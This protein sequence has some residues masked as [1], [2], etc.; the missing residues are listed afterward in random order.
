[1]KC[2][3]HFDDFDQFKQAYENVAH[4][5]H[6]DYV[7]KIKPSLDTHHLTITVNLGCE[8]KTKYRKFLPLIGEVQLRF[9]YPTTK[10]I[11]TPILEELQYSKDIKVLISRVGKLYFDVRDFSDHH[12]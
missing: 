8:A 12:W 4:G 5:R 3:A 9:G 11:I 6:K 10:E 7:I 2:G 1:M